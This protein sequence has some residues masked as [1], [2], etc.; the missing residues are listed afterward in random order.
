MNDAVGQ[1]DPLGG[2]NLSE[3]DSDTLGRGASRILVTKTTGLNQ[4]R[5][6]T[7]AK[8]I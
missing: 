7:N 3:K 6:I 4:G 5:V 8:I 2:F 1:S